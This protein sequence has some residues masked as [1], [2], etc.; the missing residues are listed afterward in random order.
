[1]TKEADNNVAAPRILENQN[2][3]R[4]INARLGRQAPTECSTFAVCKFW[5]T[6]GAALLERMSGLNIL[7]L[8]FVW[9]VGWAVGVS[10]M[11]P[12]DLSSTAGEARTRDE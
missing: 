10:D 6:L 12:R 1:M 7:A 8:F 3:S 2:Y 11:S 5:S 4:L 9:G